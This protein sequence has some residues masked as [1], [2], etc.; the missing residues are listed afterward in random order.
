MVG[1]Y[2]GKRHP[3]QDVGPEMGEGGWG[4]CSKVGLYPEL[5]SISTKKKENEYKLSMLEFHFFLG[6]R[7]T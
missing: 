6:D 7:H 4:I 1:V 2:P 3:L 5:Y